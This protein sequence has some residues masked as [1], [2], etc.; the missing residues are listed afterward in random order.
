MYVDD[1]KSNHFFLVFLV[2]CQ[3]KDTFVMLEK[4]SN[5]GSPTPSTKKFLWQAPPNTM[6]LFG[7]HHIP[8]Y[9]IE[10]CIFVKDAQY[11][12]TTKD[13]KRLK[14]MSSPLVGAQ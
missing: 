5:G 6:P 13:K 3:F 12:F 8:I 11:K 1:T 9:Q 2:F 7:A 14:G 4:G 10:A